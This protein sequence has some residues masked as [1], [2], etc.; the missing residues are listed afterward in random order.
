MM[1]IE[2]DRHFKNPVAAAAR[3]FDTTIEPGRGATQQRHS[4]EASDY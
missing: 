2:V 4:T 1:S 3:C